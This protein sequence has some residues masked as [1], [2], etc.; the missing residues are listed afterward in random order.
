MARLP[1]HQVRLLIGGK[2]SGLRNPSRAMRALGA[3]TLTLEALVLLLAIQPIRITQETI[4]VWQLAVLLG[5]V[6]WAVLCTGLL[7]WRWGW[8]LGG[9]LQLAL[10]AGGYLHW[11]IGVVG[12]IFGLVWL[13]VLHVR[14]RV[15]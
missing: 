15:R 7:R 9:L 6:V 5:G 12:L 4:T 14:R 1:S 2:P 8:W 3:I 11:T 10:V 13:Y